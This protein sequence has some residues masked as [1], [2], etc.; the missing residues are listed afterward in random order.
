MKD[1]EEMEHNQRKIKHKGRGEKTRKKE[2]NKQTNRRRKK[3]N[4]H[5][6]LSSHTTFRTNSRLLDS[7]ALH[8]ESRGPH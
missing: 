6:R 2:T 1:Q 4:R 5:S 8:L 7:K 3:S